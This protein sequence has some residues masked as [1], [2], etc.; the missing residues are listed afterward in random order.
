MG[1]CVH[2]TCVMHMCKRTPDLVELELW[3]VVSYLMCVMSSF[4]SLT[5]FFLYPS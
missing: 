3:A 5:V 2:V 1:T 4:I